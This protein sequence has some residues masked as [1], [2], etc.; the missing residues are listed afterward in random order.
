ARGGVYHLLGHHDKGFADRDKAIE[1]DPKMPEAWLARGSAHFLLEHYAKA[2]ADLEKALQLN[3]VLEEAKDVL[4]RTNEKLKPATAPA[5]TPKPIAQQESSLTAVHTLAEKHLE[6]PA[7]TAQQPTQPVA[8]PVVAAPVRQAPA[9]SVAAK[10]V[11]PKA[12]KASVPAPMAEP[13]AD[14]DSKQGLSAD[15]LNF[16]GRELNQAGDFKK[17]IEMFSQAVAKKPD[18]FIAYNGR[19]YSHMRLGEWKQAEE[20]YTLA[21]KYN[22]RYAN[23]YKNRSAARVKLGDTAGAQQDSAMAKQLGSN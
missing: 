5:L 10:L 7:V 4:D 19:G 14:A 3:P 8:A 9:Q 22:P 17:A 23:A 15:N 2:K 20:N 6:L 11:E 12:P 1:L 18:F 13:G 16:L 21:L